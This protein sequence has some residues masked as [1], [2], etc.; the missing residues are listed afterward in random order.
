MK[1]RPALCFL[2]LLLQLPA[3]GTQPPPSCFSGE[4]C[5]CRAGMQISADPLRFFPPAVSHPGCDLLPEQ[6]EVTVVAGM[7]GCRF[8]H[9]CKHK[10]QPL[11]L[12]LINNIRSMLISLHV[13]I[14]FF[15]WLCFSLVFLTKPFRL[16]LNQ[17]D[18]RIDGQ[19][20]PLHFRTTEQ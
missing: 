7:T 3:G 6:L 10:L 20:Q 12:L 16:G 13:R 4:V 2:P 9:T 19:L 8:L 11:L 17:T 5:K 1:E 18:F 14:N 15:C